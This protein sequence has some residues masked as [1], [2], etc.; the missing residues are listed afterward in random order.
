MTADVTTGD[1]AAGDFNGDGIADV[2][3][4]WGELG[5]WWQDGTTSV[6]GTPPVWEQLDPVPA[7]SLTAGDVTGDGR[8]ELI[9]TWDNGIWYYDF[10]ATTWTQMTADVTTGD[11]AAGDFN[12]DGIADVA[13]NWGELG[14]W[15]Q[16]GTTS[17]L[18]T[19]PVW[20]QLDP[21][22]AYSLTAGDITGDGRVE[23]IGTWDNGI[24]YYD[25][26]AEEWI[27][28]TAD[29]TTGDIAAGDFNADGIADVASNW[30]NGLWWQDGT[31]SVLGTPE[32][33][34]LLDPVPAYSLTAGDVTGQ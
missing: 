17:V 12:G 30:D 31:T 8:V 10:V 5:L 21:M 32:V 3:S 13:S 4:N 29:V 11:I 2:A 15:W 28:M 7:Y 25:F 19:P 14:L 22:P 24:W 18:G 1:I 33:W 9:G 23:L 6:L 16:D 27:Q 34:E 26:V 20:D